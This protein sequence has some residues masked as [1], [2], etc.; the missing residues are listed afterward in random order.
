[1]LPATARLMSADDHV[2][3]PPRPLG[4]PGARAVPRPTARASSRS[5]V[6]E[7]W[8]V[9]GR[10]HLHPHGVV[11]A[12][13]RASTRPGYPP[14]PG[15]ARFDEIRPGCYD[16]VERLKDMDVD[17]V[18]GQ[19]L[20]PQLRALRRPPLLPGRRQ[21][22]ELGLACLRTYNDYLL[23]EWCATAPVAAVR[24]GD[25]PA[26]RHRRGGRRAR[27]RRSPR[28][29]RR[30]RSPRTRPCSACRRSTPTTGIRSGPSRDEAEIPLCMHIG[31]LVGW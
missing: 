25:P 11:P 2:I 9:R 13:A 8:A 1:M 28:A 27:P 10:A 30:S 17:G 3:E 26:A 6:V 7:A 18:W 29:P 22:P 14:A 20:L 16:P 31:E 24:R 23:D 15:T 5:T 12:A 19:L 4:R 21:D